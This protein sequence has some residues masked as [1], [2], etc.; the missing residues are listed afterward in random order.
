MTHHSQF[1]CLTVVRDARPELQNN[2]ERLNFVARTEA[3][4]R[5]TF[6]ACTAEEG[7][8][9]V[10]LGSDSRNPSN[11]RFTCGVIPSSDVR[12][13]EGDGFVA[14]AV[15]P[16]T[17]YS[18]GAPP[19]ACLDE[20]GE[21]DQTRCPEGIECVGGTCADPQLT[22]SYVRG[23]INECAE[24]AWL[25]EYYPS[26]MNNTCS[27][28]ANTQPER[29]ACEVSDYL[30]PATSARVLDSGRIACECARGYTLG[31]ED[32]CVNI[33]EC[34][35]NNGGCDANATCTDTVGDRLC[36]CNDGYFGDG[37]TCDDVDECAQNN[38]GCSP[39]AECINQPGSSTCEFF[40]GDS[41]LNEGEECDDGNLVTE[42]CADCTVCQA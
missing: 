22:V 11:I 21:L 42:V 17:H 33:N 27:F 18:E 36:A 6:Q 16:Y 20:Y 5:F 9:T 34:A 40:C 32:A 30:D 31:A 7:G 41:A 14:W 4:N 28:Y 19:V 38:G 26:Y 24:R 29:F 3:P 25:A 23:C 8:V 2:L 12:L 13:T 37:L 10:P 1:K 15:V 35:L 39:F